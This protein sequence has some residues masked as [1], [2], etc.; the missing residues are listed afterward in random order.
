[1][2]S[3]ISTGRF[4]K[5]TPGEKLFDAMNVIFT[6]AFSAAMLLPMLH[7]LNVSLSEGPESIKSGF[8]FFPKG[9]LNI[10]AYIMVLQEPLLIRSYAN[11]ILYCVGGVLFTLVFTALTAYPLSIKGFRLKKLV[12]IFLT[13]T[14]FF[15]GGMVPTYLLIR[16]LGFINNVLVMII[17]FSVTAFNVILFRTFFT[18]ILGELR[19]AAIIDGASEVFVLFKMYFPLSKA[20]FATIGLFTLVAKWNDWFSALLYLNSESMYPVQ[21]ILRKIIFTQVSMTYMNNQIATMLSQRKITGENIIM[22]TII[23]TILPIT[24][25]YPFMQKYFVKGVFVGTIKG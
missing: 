21:M 24:C 9:K 16:D 19:E 8:F 10:T 6:L 20:I 12:T 25:V 14:M 23:I 11:T 7:V 4:L 15:S 2:K 3:R 5:L 13:I 18:G 1:M 22:A 17:P